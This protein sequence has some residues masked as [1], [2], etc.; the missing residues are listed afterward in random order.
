MVNR[1]RPLP[2][3][4]GLETQNPTFE[5]RVV[6]CEFDAWKDMVL[7]LDA[8][9]EHLRESVDKWQCFVRLET[10]A[11][12]PT[13]CADEDDAHTTLD[14]MTDEHENVAMAVRFTDAADG[15]KKVMLGGW[16]NPNS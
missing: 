6:E 10:D 13:E 1:P 4:M 15:K 14:E 12:T 9:F 16:V 5:T 7:M 2:L 8:H 3:L 11:E